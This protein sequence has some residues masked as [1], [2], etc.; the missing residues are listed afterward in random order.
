MTVKYLKSIEVNQYRG[1][2]LENTE[3]FRF[4]LVSF[5][6]YV[7]MVTYKI[8]KEGS[9]YICLYIQEG[10]VFLISN[11]MMEMGF[12]SIWGT[13]VNSK[14]ERDSGELSFLKTGYCST[15]DMAKVVPC[16]WSASNTTDN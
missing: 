8:L 12:G 15:T 6:R 7:K 3:S 16:G 14:Y 9:I 5:P 11:N 13:N 1:A 10:K 4:T 2:E